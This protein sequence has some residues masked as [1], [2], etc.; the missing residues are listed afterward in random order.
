MIG[1]VTRRMRSDCYA[2]C[3]GDEIKSFVTQE[4]KGV[5]SSTL[6][7]GLNIWGY[8]TRLQRGQEVKGEGHQKGDIT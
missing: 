3:K 5:A 1:H 8:Y 7:Y 6:V 4:Q 2:Y